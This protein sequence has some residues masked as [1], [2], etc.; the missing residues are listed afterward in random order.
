MSAA[1]RLPEMCLSAP[2]ALSPAIQIVAVSGFTVARTRAAR[3]GVTYPTDVSGA[4]RRYAART[5]G[6]VYSTSTV[7]ALAR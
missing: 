1:T 6:S 3:H 4:E 5:R 7:R 2:G